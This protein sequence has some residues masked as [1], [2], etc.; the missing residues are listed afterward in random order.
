MRTRVRRKALQ[1]KKQILKVLK[2]KEMTYKDLER[3]INTNSETI[4][5]QIKELEYLGFV[6]TTKHE[7]SK[8]TGRPFTTIKLIKIP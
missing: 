1:I 7:K 4:K 5:T 3:K 8:H 6:K 2:N